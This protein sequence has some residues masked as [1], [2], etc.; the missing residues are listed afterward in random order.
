M[1]RK[2]NGYLEDYAQKCLT[3]EIVAGQELKRELRKLLR[4]MNEPGYIYDTTAADVRLSFMTGCIRLTKSPFYGQPMRLLEW[5]KAWI[6]ALFGF[7]MAENET[8]RFRRT[9]LLIA[10]KN[11]KSETCSALALTEMILGGRGE[12]IVCSSNDD[13]Q[14]NILYDAVNTMRVMIDPRSRETWKNQQCI[15][16]KINGSKIFKL[17]QTTK[18]KEGRNIDFGIVDECHEMRDAVI[19][20]SIE[21]SQSLKPNPKLI[22]I[23]TEGRTNGGF[24]D[25]ELSRARAILNDEVDDDAARRYLPWF[26]SQDSEQ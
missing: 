18:N 7:L 25:E 8:Q 16:C 26:Y 10:R 24:L 21:Q 4:E 14:A 2:T 19:V 22:L 12:D 6:S 1:I 3:G 20:K 13:K 17:S 11:A 15:S 5:Q 9:L 23:T